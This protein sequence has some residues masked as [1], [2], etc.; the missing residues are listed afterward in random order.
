VWKARLTD[1]CPRE[2]AMMGA[3]RCSGRVPMVTSSS[4][5]DMACAGSI[6]PPAKCKKTKMMKER[7]KFKR[8]RA[9]TRREAHNQETTRSR[10]AAVACRLLRM[11]RPLAVQI[12]STHTPSQLVGLV[13]TWSDFS[14]FRPWDQLPSAAK[15]VRS[16]T[17]LRKRPCCSLR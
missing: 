2:R 7:L 1:G 3:S 9:G 11:A 10:T 15:V 17:T 13:G 6:S 8:M 4:Q 16:T 12:A 5:S 14:K